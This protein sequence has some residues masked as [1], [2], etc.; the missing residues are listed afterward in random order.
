VGSESKRRSGASEVRVDI[1]HV[2]DQPGTCQVRRLRRAELVFSSHAMKPDRCLTDPDFAMH[3][4]AVGCALDTPSFE[5]ER[6]DQ[7]VMSRLDVLVHQQRDNAC[8]GR[9]EF[10]L[11]LCKSDNTG[12]LCSSF[13]HGH[14]GGFFKDV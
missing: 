2:D 10:S 1:R 9:H 4:L 5:T 8:E 12:E 11:V 6:F 13:A 14:G 3:W 7:E